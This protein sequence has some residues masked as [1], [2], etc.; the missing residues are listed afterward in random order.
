MEVE[1]SHRMHT[2]NRDLLART[3]ITPILS[4][5]H[6]T[7]YSGEYITSESEYGWCFVR[8]YLCAIIGFPNRLNLDL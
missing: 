6:Y 1:T 2:R 4:R 8:A 7:C 5:V 3:L